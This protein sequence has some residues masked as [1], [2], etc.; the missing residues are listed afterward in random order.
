MDGTAVCIAGE[1]RAL[2][3]KQVQERLRQA[4]LEPLQADSFLV[5]SRTWSIGWHARYRIWQHDMLPNV[6]MKDVD[7]AIAAIRPVRAMVAGTDDE[8]F[9]MLGLSRQALDS[10]VTCS[11]DQGKATHCLPPTQV[12]LALR[13]RVCLDLIETHELSRGRPYRWVVRTRPDVV[14]SCAF[15]APLTEFRRLL[16]GRNKLMTSPRWVAYAWD[17]LAY[18][19]RAAAQIS[20]N[21]L[22]LA[23]NCSACGINITNA[24]CNACIMR[25]HDFLVTVITDNWGGVDIAR[26]CQML[27][28]ERGGFRCP[29]RRIGKGPRIAANLTGQCPSLNTTPLIGGR[30]GHQPWWN[31]NR[32]CRAQWWSGAR[33]SG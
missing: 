2:I 28:D 5:L 10:I 29:W 32:H 16:T 11:R 12:P 22:L 8:L 31:L 24:Y 14:V 21:E 23:R 26:H 6:S 9:N 25:Q 4:V 15:R 1:M 3:F 17:F 7:E 19:T 30:R 27:T 13:W 20:L 18:L 33:G